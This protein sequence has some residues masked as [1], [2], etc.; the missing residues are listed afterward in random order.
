[1]R[2]WGDRFPGCT[3]YGSFTTVTTTGAPSSLT[4]NPSPMLVAYKNADTCSTSGITLSRD[5]NGRTGFNAFA[6]NLASDAALGQ[7]FPCY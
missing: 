7:T 3:I 2:D 1:M 4:G 5:C 6:V